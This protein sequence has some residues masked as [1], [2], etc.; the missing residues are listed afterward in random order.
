MKISW[1]YPFKGFL[2]F[3]NISMELRFLKSKK[4]HMKHSW[5]LFFLKKFMNA[6]FEKCVSSL[7]ASD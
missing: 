1:D 4:T 7:Q 3:P 2:I 5:K 6:R